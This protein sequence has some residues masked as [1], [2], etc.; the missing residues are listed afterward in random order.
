MQSEGTP[1]KAE[2]APAAGGSA[3]GARGQL[4]LGRGGAAC[5][6]EIE[7]EVGR[8][9][10]VAHV[11]LHLDL[12]QRRRAEVVRDLLAALGPQPHLQAQKGAEGVRRVRGGCAC[13]CGD[14]FRAGTKGYGGL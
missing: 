2:A 13:G 3:G 11:Q 10:G 1:A 7:G 8:A 9:R 4:G 12:A 5:G 6:L 14:G